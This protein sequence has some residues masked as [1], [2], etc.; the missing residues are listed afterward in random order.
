MVDHVNELTGSRE[1]DAKGNLIKEQFLN[2]H[3]LTSEYDDMGRRIKLTLPDQSNIYYKWGPKYLDEIQRITSKERFNYRHRF[4]QYNMAGFPTKQRLS[5]GF[6]ELSFEMD[7]TLTIVAKKTR[8]QNQTDENSSSNK[9]RNITKDP[10]NYTYHHDGLGRIT[11]VVKPYQKIL[12]TYDIWNRRMSKRILDKIDG[13]WTESLHLSFLYDD[14]KEIGAI[15]EEEIWLKQLK[16]CA[17][18]LVNP[19]DQ[20]VAYELEGRP[21]IAIHDLEGNVQDL[22]SILR[23]K[24]METYA[25]SDEGVDQVFDYWNQKISYSKAKNPW[26]FQ[27]ERLDEETGLYFTGGRYYDPIKGEFI[28]PSIDPDVLATKTWN[29]RGL[30]TLSLP[31]YPEVEQAKPNWERGF[32]LPSLP[33]S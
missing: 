11:E 20:A 33:K 19:G 21:Y 5:E 24:L 13:E 31:E 32:P 1:Y 28:T 10:I 8:M 9:N 12:F 23:G 27:C 14:Q 22:Y 17:P 29:Q 6:G 7:S 18:H 30:L 4:I 15:D 16:I 25:Y 2:G 26:R 3:A